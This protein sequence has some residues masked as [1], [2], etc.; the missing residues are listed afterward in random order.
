MLPEADYVRLR[1]MATAARH[2]FEVL[3]SYRNKEDID[4]I[5]WEIWRALEG[6]E[7]VEIH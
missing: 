7:S 4:M 5:T 3:N 2:A 6:H 1:R